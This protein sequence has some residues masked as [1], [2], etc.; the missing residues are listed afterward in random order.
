MTRG[1]PEIGLLDAFADLIADRVAE[2][3]TAR[4]ADTVTNRSRSAPEPAVFLSLEQLAQELATRFPARSAPTWRR[5]L[6]ERT[7]RA[8]KTG[9]AIPGA[10]KAE[11]RWWFLLEPAL[12]WVVDGGRLG[13]RN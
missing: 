6:Y 11:S 1:Q 9:L 7:S 10:R 3:V 13:A 8:S 12:E 4:L 2:R 5:W